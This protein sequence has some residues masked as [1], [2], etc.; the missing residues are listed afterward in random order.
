MPFLGDTPVSEVT[1]THVLAAIEPIWTTKA[2]TASRL[3]RRI[4]SVLE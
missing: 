3:R 1:T 2:K 4:E